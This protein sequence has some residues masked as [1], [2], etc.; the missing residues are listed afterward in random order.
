MP[1]KKIQSKLKHSVT[2]PRK[3]F[4]TSESGKIVNELAG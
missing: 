4:E 3:I 2:E 1:K